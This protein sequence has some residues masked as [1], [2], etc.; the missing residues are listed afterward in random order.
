VVPLDA[1]PVFLVQNYGGDRAGAEKFDKNSKNDK[2]E[3]SER[4]PVSS[5]RT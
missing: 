1:L 2:N 4:T 3:K 5:H